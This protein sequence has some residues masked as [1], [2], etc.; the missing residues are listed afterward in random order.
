MVYRDFGE[1][2]QGLSDFDAAIELEQNYGLAHYA[3]GITNLNLGE[4]QGALRDFDAPSSLDPDNAAALSGRASLS[5]AW[6]VTTKRRGTSAG[7][8]P[9]TLATARPS[10][11]GAGPHQP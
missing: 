10:W 7:P 2:D 11:L 9:S 6:A 1:M 8:W 3:K 5:V 4:F